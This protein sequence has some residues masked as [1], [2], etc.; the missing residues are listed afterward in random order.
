[1]ASSQNQHTFY[2]DNW[3]DNV[4]RIY[5]KN[6]KKYSLTVENFPQG[7]AGLNSKYEHA[8]EPEI[9]NEFRKGNETAFIYLYD[10]YFSLLYSFR[11]QFTFNRELVKDCIQKLFIYIFVR[12]HRLSETVSVKSYLLKAFRRRLLDELK[13]E[14]KFLNRQ[15]NAEGLQFSFEISHEQRIINQQVDQEKKDK[16]NQAIE[17]LT[18]RQREAIYYFYYHT[19]NICEIKEIMHF[20]SV[21]ATQNLIYRAL[22]ILRK[23]LG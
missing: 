8:S 19:L 16:L 17:N 13:K 18:S 1:M 4:P 2:S 7:S 9:W 21:K 5:Q 10:K 11:H 22:K 6:S 14:R 20:G 3:K 23:Q 15:Q 12:K